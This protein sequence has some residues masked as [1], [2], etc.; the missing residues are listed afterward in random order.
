MADQVKIES[1]GA[2]HSF[3]ILKE[4]LKK[5]KG[6]LKQ[7]SK[8]F[9]NQPSSSLLPS[10]VRSAE[11]IA[12]NQRKLMTPIDDYL[13]MTKHWIKLILKENGYGIPLFKLQN[14]L[15]SKLTSD[16]DPSAFNCKSLYDFLL[17]YADD[18]VDIEIKKTMVLIYPKNHRFSSV[19]IDLDPQKEN[20][21]SNFEP[22]YQ[23]FIKP[24]QP[25]RFNLENEGPPGLGF[26]MGQKGKKQSNSGVM[27]PIL[28]YG[29][30]DNE[31]KVLR[32]STKGS[33]QS[34]FFNIDLSSGNEN[35]TTNSSIGNLS[36]FN[37]KLGRTLEESNLEI[38]DNLKFIENLLRDNEEDSTLFTT[39]TNDRNESFA[40]DIVLNLPEISAIND[41]R[42]FFDRNSKSREFGSIQ[43]DSVNS[44]KSMRNF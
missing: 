20:Y 15:N 34:S 19:P 42:Y 16:F 5:L 40:N 8:P 2:N 33:K 28:V 32:K 31:E 23:H 41:S 38:K 27:T 1:S 13:A 21:I 9:S 14:E 36:R 25:D 39:F 26:N 12:T 44:K 22:K 43:R 10:Q 18:L 7:F 6:P 30:D 29:E 4:P 11:A 37:S 17:N 3:A 35:L 24:F